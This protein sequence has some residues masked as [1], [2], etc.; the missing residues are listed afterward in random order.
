MTRLLL[1]GGTIEARE[2]AQDLRKC[3]GL[4]LFYSLAG[5]T[6]KAVHVDGN[7]RRG[8][9]GGV[10]GLER[11]LR[12]S[13]IDLLLDATHPHAAEISKNA[14]EAAQRC[15]ISR[16]QLHREAWTARPGDT[17][18]EFDSLKEM[19]AD[20]PAKARVFV[21]VGSQGLE[22]FAMRQ[23]VFFLV[24]SIE[25]PNFSD[26]SDFKR[27]FPSGELLLERGPFELEGERALLQKW[28]IELLASKNSGGDATRA[29]I[30]AAREL[31]I[32][33]WMLASPPPVPGTRVKNVSEAFDW[34]AG[35]LR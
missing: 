20:L 8:G 11:F 1:L 17:W 9:F 16:A 6:Q 21:S 19:A 4:E 12:E 31:H 7:V 14:A 34:V 28:K 33:V 5:R 22:D 32:P 30:D 10:A 23:D 3:R 25:S 24:R 35:Q 27:H 29:K 2:L 18:R 13:N 26:G 15:N